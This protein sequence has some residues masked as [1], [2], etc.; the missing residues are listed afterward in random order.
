MKKLDKILS[1]AVGTSVAETG[2]NDFIFIKAFLMGHII[3]KYNRDI[4]EE[5]MNYINLIKNKLEFFNINELTNEQKQYI[6]TFIGPRSD[7]IMDMVK[8]NPNERFDNE[9][10]ELELIKNIIKVFVD[11]KIRGVITAPKT[12]ESIEVVTEIVNN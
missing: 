4:T 3:G 12:K 11:K 10:K 1:L 8:Q 2:K 9:I 6:Y 7:A 5:E